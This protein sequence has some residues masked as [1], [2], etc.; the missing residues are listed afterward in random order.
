MSNYSYE[1]YESVNFVCVHILKASW[2][3]R[4]VRN[5][6]CSSMMCALHEELYKLYNIQLELYTVRTIRLELYD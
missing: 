6:W 1:S 5:E 4:R 3:L 2:T